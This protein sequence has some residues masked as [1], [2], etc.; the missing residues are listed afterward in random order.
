MN[1][2]TDHFLLWLSIS[3]NCELRDRASNEHAHQEVD[4]KGECPSEK[5][6]GTL[7]PP[8]KFEAAF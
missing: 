6:G 3:V 4:E 5:E 1:I 7:K 8:R 2:W